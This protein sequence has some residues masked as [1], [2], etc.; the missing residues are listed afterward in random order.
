M[1]KCLLAGLFLLVAGCSVP[2]E[3]SEPDTDPLYFESIGRGQHGAR[4]DTIE[5]VAR[6]AEAW[7]ELSAT[8]RPIA[9]FEAVNF[10]QQM[11]A[12]IAIPTESG[13]YTIEVESVEALDGVITVAYVVNVP[14]IDCITPTALALPFQA[15]SIRKAEGAVEFERRNE[16]FKCGM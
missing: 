1:S 11:A 13:G 5:T 14:G 15:V 12:L 2:Q 16:P 9:E 8:V 6:T 7:A 4:R 10:E 3:E